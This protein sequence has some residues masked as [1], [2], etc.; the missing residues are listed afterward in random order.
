MGW[1]VGG[2]SSPFH[3]AEGRQGVFKN[4][5]PTGTPPLLQPCCTRVASW[6]VTPPG[7]PM[8]QLLSAGRQA[9]RGCRLWTPAFGSLGPRGG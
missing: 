3:S 7:A 1:G 5:P 8:R 6:E 2:W 4:K 9:R